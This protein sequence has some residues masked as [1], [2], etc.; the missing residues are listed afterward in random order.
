LKKRA[1][2]GKDFPA[3]T[4]VFHRMFTRLGLHGRPPCFAVEFYPYAN[5]T[6][7]IR[8]D[9]DVVRVRLSDIFA[10]APLPVLEA[11]A[12]ILLGRLYR[13]RSPRPLLRIYQD[14][15]LASETRRRLRQ[16]RRD[17][18]R[19]IKDAPEGLH[20]DLHPL[21]D[22][23]N[24]RY[25]AGKLQRPRL[26]WSRRPWRAQLGCFDPALNQI[27]MSSRL[28]QSSVPGYVVE[29]VLYHEM[30][31]VKHPIR[32]ASCGLQSHSSAFRKQEQR[33]EDYARARA[34]LERLR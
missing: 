21:F 9:E 18:G 24:Q 28:D 7:T 5:L 26:G 14:Y 20:Y 4:G 1:T 2:S 8:L 25:F 29:Y 15:A 12:G 27:V 19:K 30:L 34:F 32:R 22:N 10:S 31:H 33:F 13:S 23:L 6:H 11:T 17:R 16:L 3:G